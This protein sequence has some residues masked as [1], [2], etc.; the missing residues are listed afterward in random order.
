M[1]KVAIDNNQK[2]IEYTLDLFIVPIIDMNIGM[3]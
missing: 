3:V 2:I 1:Q